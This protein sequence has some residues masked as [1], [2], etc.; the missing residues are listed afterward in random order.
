MIN[1]KESL[2]WIHWTTVNSI[3]QKAL[4]AI[5]TDA[6]LEDSLSETGGYYGYAVATTGSGDDA[7]IIVGAYGANSSAGSAYIYTRSGT[8]WTLEQVINNPSPV[9]ND[10][11][12]YSVSIA[13]TGDD[14]TVIIGAYYEDTG[15]SAAGSAYI[16]TRSGTTWS[17][18]QEINNP[19]PASSDY[20]GWSVAITGK[21]DQS[22]AIMGAYGEDTGES[23]AGTVYIYTRSGTTWTL[24]QEINNP[25]PT[26]NDYFGDSVSIIGEGDD[27]LVIIGAYNEDTGGGEAGSAYIYTRSGTTWTLEQEINNPSPTSGDYFACSV[28]IS[29][30]GDQSTAIMGAYGEDT[31][32]SLA[33]SAYIYTRTGDVWSLEQEINNPSPASGD[34]FGVSVSISGEGDSAICIIGA[35]GDD[36]GESSAGSCYIYTRSGTTW[37]LLEELNN[38][39]PVSS[40]Y[41]GQSVAISGDTCVGGTTGR[42][43]IFLY[44]LT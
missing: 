5:F 14:A 1:L 25:S 3:I 19:I 38:P 36:T 23:R 6:T 42:N 32:G 18:E 28:A 30:I 20:F 27:A 12:G 24:E 35:R 2:Q 40:D 26:A 31:G 43:K 16:Y 21:G 39:S 9:D 33:G 13:G 15:D 10:R 11:F 17:L 41:F 8:T 22:T 37:T 4:D 29:G 7:T 34:E 44:K